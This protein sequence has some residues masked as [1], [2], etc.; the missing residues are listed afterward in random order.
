MALF[1]PRS[2]PPDSDLDRIAASSSQ[3]LGL[4]PY[5]CQLQA[6]REL[7]RGR[8]VEMATGEGKTLVIAL[9][10]C[11]A[12]AQAP[13]H[14][15]TANDYLAERDSQ[16]M[17]PLYRAQNLQVAF[18]RPNQSRDERRQAYAADVVYAT[19]HELG[20]DWLRDNL[21]L[22]AQDLVQPR[23]G[24]AIIDEVDAVLLDEAQTPLIIAAH[25]PFDSRAL[26][27]ACAVVSG[28]EPGTHFTLDEKRKQ[29]ALT[30]AGQTELDRRLRPAGNGELYGLA[31]ADLLHGAHAALQA[32]ALYRAGRDYLVQNGQLVL[33]DAE[34]GR[35]LQGRRL[36]GGTHEA[37]EVLEGI[38]V[39]EQQKTL[40][41]ITYPEF[42][43]LYSKVCGLSG[44]LMTDR[45]ELHEL[46]GL[47]VVRVPR[48][49]PDQRRILPDAVFPSLAEKREHLLRQVRQA[50]QRG[51]PVLVGCGSV[52]EAVHLGQFLQEQEI[53]VRVLSAIKPQDEVDIIAHAGEPG[54]VTVAT[55]MAGRGTDIV[56]GGPNGERRDQVL[57]AGG[58]VVIG[59]SRSAL[60]RV[61]D[62]LA[63]RCGRQGDPGEVQFL[64]S[65]DDPLLRFAR[66]VAALMKPARLARLVQTAQ[67]HAAALQLSQRER[68]ERMGGVIAHQRTMFYALRRAVLEQQ[69]PDAEGTSLLPTLDEAWG[70]YLE[71]AQAK[72]DL[73]FLKSRRSSAMPDYQREL[74][75]DFYRILDAALE[76]NA[77]PPED[78]PE[79]ALDA[80]LEHGRWVSRNAACPCGSGKRYKNCHG[81]PAWLF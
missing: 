57:A 45:R 5:P 72:Q 52:R 22:R 38:E 37:L 78:L 14:V 61:D 58:L 8:L 65:L 69:S 11:H 73:F 44:T 49:K 31:N 51:A 79:G 25:R 35:L 71:L 6:A 1:S 46:Y 53:P 36:A 21:A 75:M 15:V 50:H 56:L 67:A 54:A 76:P 59:T 9:A 7:Q 64:I 63:G 28:L 55:H 66:P 34:T 18:L 12:A 80:P 16:R 17:A 40:A 19:A 10:A 42:F 26:R 81:R 74:G 70:S 3:A 29:V 27:L 13:V 32:R 41:S 33:V 24:T 47:R 68:Q 20:F 48:N 4:S 30:E 43:K 23:F 39:G 62:Q 2:S 77:D 60:R